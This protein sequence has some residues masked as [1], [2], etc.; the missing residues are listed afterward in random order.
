M[1][2]FE[3]VLTPW[4]SV[5]I[6]FLLKICLLLSIFPTVKGQ[7]QQLLN[8]FND[9]VHT[10]N[11]IENILKYKAQITIESAWNPNA[12][13]IYASGLAQ[14]TPDT[15]KTYARLTKPECVDKPETDPACSIRTQI[16]FM[17][18]LVARY[19]FTYEPWKFAWAAYDGGPGYV[20]KQ[21]QKCK[22]SYQCNSK[23]W[24]D[25]VADQCLS[26]R[27]SGNCKENNEYPVKI[28]K[29]LSTY[30]LKKGQ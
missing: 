2:L 13:S 7:S 11:Q 29:V 10:A 6:V 12:H 21:I 30:E 17:D 15:W 18:R 8:I 16:L 4:P 25:N 23:K 24:T 9:E 28:G 19:R 20:S 1:K 27:S 3:T 5:W 22:M 14:F 26:F